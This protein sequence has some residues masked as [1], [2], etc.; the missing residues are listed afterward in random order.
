[1]FFFNALIFIYTSYKKAE[2]LSIENFLDI[3]YFNNHNS[4]EVLTRVIVDFILVSIRLC[5]NYLIIIT[6]F[7]VSSF[8]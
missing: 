3:Y 6:L 2:I 8:S 5:C 4:H 1:M 7:F